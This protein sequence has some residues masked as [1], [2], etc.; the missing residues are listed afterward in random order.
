MQVEKRD[1]R[2]EPFTVEK[3]RGQ[4]EF[5][6]K[7]TKISPIE[8]ESLIHFPQKEVIKA[9]EIQKILISTAVN[10]I[11]VDN[12]EWNYIAGR[13][14]MFNLTEIFTKEQNMKCKIGKNT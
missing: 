9:E 6:V 11:D 13:A 14:S 4:I 7:G 2:R 1:G 5:S 3:T 10:K 12:E 8:F